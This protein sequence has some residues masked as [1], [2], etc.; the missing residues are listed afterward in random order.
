ML[1]L[2]PVS[3]ALNANIQVASSS[4]PFTQLTQTVI[5]EHLTRYILIIFIRSVLENRCLKVN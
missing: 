2:A 3:Y 4:R 5:R 1:I